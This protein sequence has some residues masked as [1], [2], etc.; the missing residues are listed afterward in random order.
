MRRIRISGAVPPLLMHG[1]DR[2]KI[3]FAFVFLI[4]D[5]RYRNKWLI[6]LAA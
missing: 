1:I 4:C 2:D 5:V 3:S 6:A